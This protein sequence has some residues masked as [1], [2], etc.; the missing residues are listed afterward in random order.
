MPELPNEM[1]TN[2]DPAN[3][4]SDREA[5]PFAASPLE[6]WKRVKENFAKGVTYY[7]LYLYNGS[8]EMP[9]PLEGPFVVGEYHEEF[10]RTDDG[11]KIRRREAHIV[12]RKRS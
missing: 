1:Q 3:G 9:Y 10:V 12:F 5:N 6:S 4:G 2:G 8:E 11:W 7:A